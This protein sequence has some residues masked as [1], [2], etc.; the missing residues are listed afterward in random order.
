MLAELRRSNELLTLEGL[1]SGLV[2]Q[3]ADVELACFGDPFGR[4]FFD[5]GPPPGWYT[6][7]IE[8]DSEMWA[9]AT[10]S[11][12]DIVG[13]SRQAWEHSDRTIEAL[14]LYALGRG[15]W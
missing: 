14:A 2:K 3:V 12:E 13:L 1:L 5:E 9:T 6:E 7:D 15:P 4:P 10:E 8:R 11:R